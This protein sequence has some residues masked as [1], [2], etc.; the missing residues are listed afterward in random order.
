VRAFG[1]AATL[2]A[3]AAL[4]AAL[5]REALGATGWVPGIL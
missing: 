1:F 5:T 4:A 2:A 3:C